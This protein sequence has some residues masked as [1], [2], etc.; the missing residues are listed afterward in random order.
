MSAITPKSA[1]CTART[2]TLI[3]SVSPAGTNMP[4]SL[5]AH[6]LKIRSCLFMRASLYQVQN[7][8]GHVHVSAQIGVV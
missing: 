6:S 2:G 5:S 4:P 8:L 3:I 1:F 7:S